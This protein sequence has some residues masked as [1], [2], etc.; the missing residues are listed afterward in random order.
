[1][2][3]CCVHACSLPPDHTVP[4]I[5]GCCWITCFPKLGV[6]MKLAELRSM[7]LNWVANR[8]SLWPV[9]P[10]SLSRCD[11]W[12]FHFQDCHTWQFLQFLFGISMY[13][14]YPDQALI[15]LVWLVKNCAEFTKG[16]HCWDEAQC[17]CWKNVWKCLENWFVVSVF[18]WL[19]S[20]DF[21]RPRPV[22]HRPCLSEVLSATSLSSV[23]PTGESVPRRSNGCRHNTP[24]QRNNIMETLLVGSRCQDCL[25]SYLYKTCYSIAITL[26]AFSNLWEPCVLR[27]LQRRPCFGSDRSGCLMSAAEC[28][29]AS[30]QRRR[31]LGWRTCSGDLLQ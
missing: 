26:Q 28:S 4:S 1:M 9:H 19:T 30:C 25:C 12:M 21:A 18:G 5:F 14:N 20:V 17:L 23:V 11:D 29:R 13:K 24:V 3:C 7:R 31:S 16:I 2:L 10:V 27:H 8:P 6:C 22:L 15:G